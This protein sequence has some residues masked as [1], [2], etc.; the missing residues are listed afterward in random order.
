MSGSRHRQRDYLGWLINPK[1]KTVESYCLQ[2]GT[3]ILNAP[4]SLSGEN[5][6][7]G[8]TLDLKKIWS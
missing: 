4:S 6:L 7:F 5:I 8:F 3:E 2:T 1:Q